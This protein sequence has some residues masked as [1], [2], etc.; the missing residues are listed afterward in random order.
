M[1]GE[2]ALPGAVLERVATM[3]ADGE[4]YR[5]IAASLNRRRVAGAGNGGWR[6]STVRRVLLANRPDRVR[7]RA[8]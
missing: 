3:R 7:R 5:A 2:L 6:A 1:R 8:R 4:S